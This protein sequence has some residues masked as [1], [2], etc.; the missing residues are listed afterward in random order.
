MVYIKEN[1]SVK[2]C[3]TA[4]CISAFLIGCKQPPTA[5]EKDAVSDKQALKDAPKATEAEA[6]KALSASDADAAG[7]WTV[8]QKLKGKGN[9][10]DTFFGHSV[11]IAGNIA[12]VGASREE[13][14]GVVHVYRHEQGSWQPVLKLTANEKGNHHSF[15]HHVAIRGNYIFSSAWITDAEGGIEGVIYV[16]ENIDGKWTQTQS[17]RGSNSQNMD[18]FGAD[19]SLDDN[20][21]F[22]SAAWATGEAEKAGAV[23]VFALKDGKWVETQKI[24]DDYG[25]REGLFGAGTAVSGTNALISAPNNGK[26]GTLY[27]YK[28]EGDKWIRKQKIQPEGKAQFGRYLAL[29]GN[30]ALISS[31][32]SVEIGASEVFLYELKKE[33]WVETMKLLPKEEL[34]RKDNYGRNVAIAGNTL[35]VAA[36]GKESRSVFIFERDG[37]NWQP[38]SRIRGELSSDG[39]REP[40]GSTIKTDGKNL[41]ITSSKGISGSSKLIGSTYIYKFPSK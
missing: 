5:K 25:T 8:K 41:I 40:F 24:V 14:K 18:A 20:F 32:N 35:F 29:E 3:L 37:G 27:T 12:L 15:G 39:T 38:T 1:F 23:Y 21:V 16:F 19:L 26:T 7:R 6:A 13:T 9:R 11:D 30:I 33:H 22:V 34:S 10:E 28:L 4:L 2:F 31:P 36:D 17:L